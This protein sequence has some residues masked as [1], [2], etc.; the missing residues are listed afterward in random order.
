MAGNDEGILAR[1]RPQPA[2]AGVD[3]REH[4]HVAVFCVPAR[5][6]VNQV[7]LCVCVCGG[8]GGIGR[9]GG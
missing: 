1:Q 9:G 8:V 2:V 4:K 5:S 3:I 6:Q 7:Q